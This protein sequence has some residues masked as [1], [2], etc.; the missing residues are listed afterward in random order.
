MNPI[1]W[2]VDSTEAEFRISIAQDFGCHK[3]KFSGFRN[4]D[5]LTWNESSYSRA[6]F[7]QTSYNLLVIVLTFSDEVDSLLCERKEGE[8]E[9]SRRM[10]TEFLVSFD[11]VSAK[12][13]L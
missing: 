3:N 1:Q 8:Q 4:L 10:K 13:S 12:T 7:C 6:N 2:N 9:H 11:G 5:Y